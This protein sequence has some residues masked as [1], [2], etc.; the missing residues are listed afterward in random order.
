MNDPPL[1][2]LFAGILGLLLLASLAGWIMHRA[3]KTPQGR[4]TVDNF[5]ARTR[6]WWWMVAIFA[7]ASLLGRM[8]TVAFF[9]LISFLALREFITLTP[10]RPA[11]HRTLFW[12]FF[13]ILPYQYVLLALDMYGFFIMFIPVYAF[14]FIPARSS[15][16]A[17]PE[18]FLQRTAVM[19]WGLMICVYC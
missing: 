18:N 8:V 1:L 13:V 10:T 17:D 11:D 14:L 3:A 7:V 6:A 4:A 12:L 2:W 5:N 9:G 19:Q 16:Q 15:L